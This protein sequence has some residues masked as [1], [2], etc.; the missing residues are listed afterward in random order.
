MAVAKSAM[1]LLKNRSSNSTGDENCSGGGFVG[2]VSARQPGDAGLTVLYRGAVVALRVLVPSPGA[3]ATFPAPANFID[4]LVF[5]KLRLLN[6]T[7]S[8]PASDEVFLRRLYIDTIA[9]LPPA[10]EVKAFAAD[11]DPRKREKAVDKLLAH[12]PRLSPERKL[13]SLFRAE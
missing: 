11:P 12:L 13:D 4:A 2:R 5:D 8:G 7:P 9:Q 1:A 6:M 3:P 10:A